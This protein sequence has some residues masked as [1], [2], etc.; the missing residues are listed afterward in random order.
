M[1]VVYPTMPLSIV[2]VVS[3]SLI[4][5]LVASV[6]SGGRLVGR[7]LSYLIRIVHGRIIISWRS[8]ALLSVLILRALPGEMTC[9]FTVKTTLARLVL[10]SKN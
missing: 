3:S 10:S 2:S 4:I 1:S 5:P 6:I 8:A 9:F 7:S